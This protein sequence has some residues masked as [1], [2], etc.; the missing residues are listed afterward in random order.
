MC[1]QNRGMMVVNE[2]TAPPA[3][4]SVGRRRSTRTQRSASRERLVEII[5]MA[6]STVTAGVNVG[7]RVK[8][9]STS[10]KPVSRSRMALNKI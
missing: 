8:M 10:G 7:N 9:E 5:T 1:T 6:Q 4:S 3:P 2:S